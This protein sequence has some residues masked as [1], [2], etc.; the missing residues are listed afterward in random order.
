M[1]GKRTDP[2]PAKLLQPNEGSATADHTSAAASEV[3][4]TSIPAL[5]A[6]Q[7]CEEL[8]YRNGVKIADFWMLAHSVREEFFESALFADPAWDIL[9]ELHRAGYRGEK[10]KITSLSASARVPQ[11]TSGRWVRVLT[12]KGLIVREIDPL[13]KRRVHVRLSP[14]GQDLMRQ[15]FNVLIRKGGAIID[16]WS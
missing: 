3:Q 6:M 7:P 9:L 12:R 16:F 14:M 11:S 15:Y 13:D 2:P 8:S 4:N 10:V 1:S 5:P